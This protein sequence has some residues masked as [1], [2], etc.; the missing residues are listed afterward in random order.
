MDNAARVERHG[1][2]RVVYPD[3]YTAKR[4]GENLSALL[5]DSEVTERAAD[6][7][8]LVR[9][10]DGATAAATTIGAYSS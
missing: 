8:E 4:V 7:G 1:V 3:W 5:S 2:A 10:E 9:A 6:L